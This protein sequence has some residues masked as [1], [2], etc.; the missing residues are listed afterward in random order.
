MTFRKRISTIEAERATATETAAIS[1]KRSRRLP[2]KSG[3]M[4]PSRAPTSPSVRPC[5]Q[6]GAGQSSDL[7]KQLQN[8]QLHIA[9][10]DRQIQD[11]SASRHCMSN[12]VRCRP[13]FLW[14]CCRYVS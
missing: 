9:E 14:P 11:S 13:P 3:A 1:T 6:S 10:F 8:A 12:W 5:T 7:Q 2:P 4:G